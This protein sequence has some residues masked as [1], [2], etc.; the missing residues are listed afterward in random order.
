MALQTTSCPLDPLSVLD[1]E[2]KYLKTLDATA[3]WPYLR[4]SLANT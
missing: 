1:P 2:K 3:S 4:C